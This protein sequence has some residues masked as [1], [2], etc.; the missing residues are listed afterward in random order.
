MYRSIFVRPPLRNTL[1]R[2]HVQRVSWQVQYYE[3]EVKDTHGHVYDFVYD[4]Y[5]FIEYQYINQSTQK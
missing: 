3:H 1:N 5:I 2:V 4:I